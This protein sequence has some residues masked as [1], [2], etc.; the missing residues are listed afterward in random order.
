M[1]EPRPDHLPDGAL[2]ALSEALAV[3]GDRWTLQVVAA[4]L[5][6]PR[7]FGEL[8]QAGAAEIVQP[9]ADAVAE[10]LARLLEDR[11]LADSL[12]ERG[13]EFAAQKMSPE[14]AARTVAGLLRE[15]AG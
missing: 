11:A 13:R 15:V 6:G 5:D 9:R 2:A 10:A 12:G 8:V 4:L 1:N 3:V 14:R 7:R